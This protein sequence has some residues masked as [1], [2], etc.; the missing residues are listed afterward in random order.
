MFHGRAQSVRP[1]FPTLDYLSATCFVLVP[2]V[3]ELGAVPVKSTS[4]IPPV[5]S[6]TELGYFNEMRRITWRAGSMATV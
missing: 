6:N 2:T 1:F 5:V 4:T 3:Q